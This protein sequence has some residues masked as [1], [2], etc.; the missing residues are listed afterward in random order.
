[1]MVGE[2]QLPEA[3]GVVAGF[4]PSRRICDDELEK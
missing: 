1:M 4:L 2:S 3:V